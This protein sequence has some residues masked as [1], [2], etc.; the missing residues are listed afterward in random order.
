MRDWSPRDPDYPTELIEKLKPKID[1]QIVK[2]ISAS[3]YGFD[4]PEHKAAIRRILDEKRVPRPIQ[5]EPGEPFS[6]CMWWEADKHS[7]HEIGNLSKSQA[8]IA[9]AFSCACLLTDTEYGA[10]EPIDPMVRLVDSIDRLDIKLAAP[11]FDFLCWI[12]QGRESKTDEDS[13]FES[14][15]AELCKCLLKA[16]DPSCPMDLTVAIPELINA[17]RSLRERV[18]A[19]DEAIGHT[20]VN[21]RDW[22]QW[23]V[24]MSFFDQSWNIMF[25]LVRKLLRNP[26]P[27]LRAPERDAC[28]TLADLILKD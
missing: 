14:L 25:D 3:D 17:E 15:T 10:G 5:W 28:R 22:G 6:L 12:Q 27:A 2:A 13:R 23:L 20:H 26:N 11:C 24:G 4:D 1:Q 16:M 8:N 18:E 7:C 19:E 9:C 21:Y